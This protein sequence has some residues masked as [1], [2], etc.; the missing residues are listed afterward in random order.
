MAGRTA[1]ASLGRSAQDGAV[2]AD[3]FWMIVGLALII[4]EVLT[5]TFYLLMLGVAAFGA[6]GAAWFG[7]AFGVQALVA[8]TVAAIGCYGV[9]LY[10]GRNAGSQMPPLDR[11]Q[12]ATFEHWVDEGARLARVQYRGASWEAIVESADRALA[13]GSHLYVTATHGNTL[14]VATHRPG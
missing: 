12:P 14:T 10:R 7:F 13:P 9:H 8:G 3:F 1:V 5:G 4:A 11:G 6:A 2:A